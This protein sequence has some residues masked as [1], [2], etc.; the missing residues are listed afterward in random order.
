MAFS[1]V[2]H[3]TRATLSSFH[4]T[5]FEDST[6]PGQARSPPA[7]PQIGLGWPV[8]PARL[9]HLRSQPVP[10]VAP[11]PISSSASSLAKA[12]GAPGVRPCQGPGWR[13]GPALRPGPPRSPG[14]PAARALPWEGR[15]QRRARQAWR[16]LLWGEAAPSAPG[17]RGGK[18]PRGRGPG[19][20]GRRDR[21]AA[22]AA[23]PGLLGRP[24]QGGHRHC[25]A[26]PRPPA[27]PRTLTWLR[28]V[29]RTSRCLCA[30]AAR[31]G[32]AA[33]AAVAAAGACPSLRPAACR[34]PLPWPAEPHPLGSRGA[35]TPG[36]AR[37][38]LRPLWVTAPARGRG[39]HGL[40]KNGDPGDARVSWGKGSRCGSTTQTLK[41]AGGG[42]VGR[43]RPLL[44]SQTTPAVDPGS[45]HSW[46]GLVGGKAAGRPATPPSHTSW[47]QSSSASS[48]ASVSP[49]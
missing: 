7:R 32:R 42:T 24:R 38:S 3:C 31:P 28:W 34:A 13:P 48:P 33:A 4:Y 39:V 40:A 44:R 5:R 49:L 30:L 45:R 43:P 23:D 35:R 2:P 27:T 1:E 10:F 25:S 26:R 9:A 12:A 6:A 46:G 20:G 16:R 14:A 21:A 8:R 15:R 22:G 47:V 37:G 11:L 36:G 19:D 29:A 17:G 18:T 41:T